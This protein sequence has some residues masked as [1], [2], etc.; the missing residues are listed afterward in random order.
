[1]SSVTWGFPTGNAEFIPSTIAGAPGTET[2]AYLPSVSNG[3][4]DLQ[5]QTYNPTA[6]VPGDS[7]LGS[8]IFSNQSFSL[9]TPGTGIAFTAVA[10][11]GTVVPGM[12]GGIFSY[13]L[14]SSSSHSEI[15]FESLSDIAAVANNQE[16]TNIYQNAPTNSVGNPV[17]V[18]AQ[19]LTVF[20]TY[21]IEWFPSEVLGSS[22]VLL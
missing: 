21:T 14:N 22:M 7:F 10:K 20:H 15:D 3:A 13:G 4:L 18:P 5:L 2:A 11:L 1:V 12:D 17:S 6:L 19:N 16:Q 8:A 9:T